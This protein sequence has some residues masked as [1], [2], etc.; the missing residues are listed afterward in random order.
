MSNGML[1]YSPC[2]HG[3]N[4]D[5]V[6]DDFEKHTGPDSDCTDQTRCAREESEGLAGLN[7]YVKQTRD[8]IR[9]IVRHRRTEFGNS[10]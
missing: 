3:M 7:A 1:A 5:D 8:I 2:K 4:A 9:N 10:S 6:C